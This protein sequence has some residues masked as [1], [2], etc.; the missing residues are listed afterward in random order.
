MTP[1]LVILLGG[2]IYVALSMKV[3][4]MLV[5]SAG[6]TPLPVVVILGPFLFMLIIS[7]RAWWFAI[8]VGLLTVVRPLPVAILSRFTIGSLFVTALVVVS[9]AD[10]AFHRRRT[11]P[12]ED[13][14][15]KCML[16]VA[17]A[18]TARVLY[19]RPGSARL[20]ETGGAGIAV[21]HLI[22]VWGFIPSVQVARTAD[23]LMRQSRVI[24]AIGLLSLA[25]GSILSLLSADGFYIGLLYH[26]QMWLVA[27]CVHAFTLSSPALSRRVSLHFYVSAFTFLFLSVLTPHRS[28]PVFALANALSVAGAYHRFRKSATVLILPTA[29]LLV[30]LATLT[31]GRLPD[32]MRRSLSTVVA[33][34]SGWDTRTREGEMGRISRFRIELTRLAWEQIV[35]TPWVGR[36]YAFSRQDF[37]ERW[38]LFDDDTLVNVAG[39]HHNAV[40]SFAV[41]MGLPA[42]LLLVWVLAD[43]FVRFCLWLRRCDDPEAKR[44]GAIVLG[45]MVCSTGQALMNGGAADLVILCA[46]LGLM[47]GMLRRRAEGP[48]EDDSGD[49]PEMTAAVA[50]ADHILPPHNGSGRGG[51]DE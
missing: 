49:V 5:R 48:G 30:L 25:L 15:P 46:L 10:L 29:L 35:Q 7:F 12:F 3:A 13:R 47:T 9:F 6:R 40:L 24:F 31:G 26:R 4:S 43:V 44:V 17:L 37:Y 32:P 51:A 21:L 28:R 2:L 34:S 50:A 22:A 16:F 8:E 14:A 38:F 36:G 20:G 19:D 1:R 45:F 41:N 11:S 42:A 33:P 18:V 39:G 27:A 23:R